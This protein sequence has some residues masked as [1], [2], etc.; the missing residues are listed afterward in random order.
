MRTRRIV[1]DYEEVLAHFQGNG[2]VLASLDRMATDE[3]IPAAVVE[4]VRGHYR[5][6]HELARTQLDSVGAQFP[7]FVTAMQERLS[8]RLA[9][10]AVKEAT[11]AQVEHGLLPPGIGEAQVE[12][13]FRSLDALRTPGRTRVRVNPAELLRKVP[14]F[15]Q[16]SS[17]DFAEITPL[18]KQHTV[19]EGEDIITQ[20]DSGAALYLIA[21]GVVR[22]LRAED[23]E[24]R[25]LGTLLAGDFFGEQALLHDEPRNATCRAVTPCF[26]YQLQ[27]AD[28][29][30]LCRRWPAIDAAVREADRARLS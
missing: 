15:R 29:E 19:T 23:G 3:G 18:L 1:R 20:G 10:L 24:A 26:L 25:A 14:F 30:E 4:E 8:R 16:L 27:R 12:E 7:E 28:F 6:W 11:E 2:W 22:V 9:L 13:V 21:R 5:H 17:A